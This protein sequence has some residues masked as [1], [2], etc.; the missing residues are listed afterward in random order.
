[1]GARAEGS[2]SV[3]G[4]AWYNRQLSVCGC[5]P[6][7]KVFPLTFHK[8]PAWLRATFV[9]GGMVLNTCFWAVPLFLLTGV[10]LLTPS[11]DG[12]AAIGRTLAGF[13]QNWI[14]VNNR[15]M[16]WGH[17]IVWRIHGVDGLDPEKWYLIVSNHISGLDILVLQKTFHRRTPFI[18]FFLKQQLIF[19]P[20]LGAAWWALDF[21]FVRRH[22]KRAQEKN[23]N[24]RAEDRK[25][26]E[27]TFRRT[28]N[29]PSAILT[30]AE[31]TRLTPEK[32]AAQESPYHH[33]LKPKYG[34]IAYALDAL[35]DRFTALLD[36]TLCYPDGAMSLWDMF[37][38]K[39]NEIVVHVEQRTIP[40]ELLN[41]DYEGDPEYRERLKAWVNGLWVEKDLL[42]ERVSKA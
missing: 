10:R 35:G 38:G 26:A 14:G 33:L 34:G 5:S 25:S 7:E 11:K 21:P 22:S 6:L 13:A 37:A 42:L 23:P 32:H 27:R 24:L 29:A 9:L 20:V 16:E 41:G 39:V 15:L 28:G 2:S 12:R 30:F 17:P 1:M 4:L 3:A 36:V 18:R 31:G 19:V 8:L 40:A